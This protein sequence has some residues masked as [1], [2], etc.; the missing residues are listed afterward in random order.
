MFWMPHVQKGLRN[1]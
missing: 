1:D